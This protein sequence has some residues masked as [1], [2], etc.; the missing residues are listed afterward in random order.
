MLAG[1]L[2]APMAGSEK[3]ATHLETAHVLFIDVVGYSKRLVNGQRCIILPKK[4][5]VPA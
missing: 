3:E 5:I 4:A 2:I 1:K